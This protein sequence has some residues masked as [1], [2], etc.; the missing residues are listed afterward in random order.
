MGTS[1]NCPFSLIPG[2][3]VFGGPVVKNSTKL[4]F[5]MESEDGYGLAFSHFHCCL[6]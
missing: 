1:K 4:G 3:G 6:R 5:L 2:Y